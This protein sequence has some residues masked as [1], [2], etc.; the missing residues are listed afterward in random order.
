MFRLVTNL[1]I[2]NH[3]CSIWIRETSE[4]YKWAYEHLK[5]LCDEYYTFRTGKVHKTSELL[6]SLAKQPSKIV[7]ASR[8]QF[9][10][11]APDKHKV[12][13]IFNPVKAYQDY[14]NEKFTEWGCREKPI[15]VD[16][17]K[18]NKPNWVIGA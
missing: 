14:L 13:G 8:T 2:K 3:P 16:W 15:R 11:A 12:T 4:N 9:V 17:S 1:L 10:V 18:R 5:A 6:K 7:Y